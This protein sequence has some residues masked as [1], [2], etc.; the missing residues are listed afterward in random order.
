MGE[1]R[2]SQVRDSGLW[3]EEHD[4]LPLKQRLKILLARSSFSDLFPDFDS[5]DDGTSNL[6]A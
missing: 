5:E 3:S 6:P 4:R 1:L 2:T